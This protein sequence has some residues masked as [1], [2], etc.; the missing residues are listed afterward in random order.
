M[1]PLG[2]SRRVLLAGGLVGTL[3]LGALSGF[4]YHAR[5][6][7]K[8]SGSESASIANAASLLLDAVK[9]APDARGSGRECGKSPL[10]DCPL[11][12]WMKG[13]AALA[14]ASGDFDRLERTFLH[15]AA[16]EPAGYGN[17]RAI[18][19]RG[20]VGARAGSLDECRL[21]CKTCHDTLRPR[22]VAEHRR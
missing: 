15:I 9:A 4:S 18:A 22:Y 17:W 13:N 20:A 1:K 7:R 5:G 2:A 3:L 10:P 21:A 16:L 12:M 14:L 19:E 8:S 11:Q 6:A